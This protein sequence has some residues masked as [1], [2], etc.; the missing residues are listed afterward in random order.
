MYVYVSNFM[1]MHSYSNLRHLHFYMYV[2]TH[3]PAIHLHT[4]INPLSP[5]VYV[6]FTCVHLPPA[7]QPF[8]LSEPFL[9]PSIPSTQRHPS[10][11]HV[12]RFTPLFHPPPFIVR[13]SRHPP[14]YLVNRPHLRTSESRSMY[15]CT[16]LGG[17][18]Y[19]FCACGVL[20][21]DR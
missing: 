4:S 19:Q 3:D 12:P 1:V 17:V 5:V 9:P 10:L 8:H 16:R 21:V 6:H 2:H 13:P 18:A 14:T 15:A 7:P 20:S 11:V